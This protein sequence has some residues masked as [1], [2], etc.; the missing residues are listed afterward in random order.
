MNIIQNGSGH[1]Y[2]SGYIYIA[3]WVNGECRTPSTM[4]EMYLR[5]TDGT[6]ETKMYVGYEGSIEYY[7]DK[8]IEG[9]DISKEYYIEARLT[10]PKNQESKENQK[11]IAKITKQGNIGICTNGNKVTVSGNNIKIEK[12]T[13]NRVLLQSI[14]KSQ[15]TDMMQETETNKQ[16]EINLEEGNEKEEVNEKIEE[17]NQQ[18]TNE[19]ETETNTENINTIVQNN[20]DS[21]LEEKNEINAIN[22]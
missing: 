9:L 12:A 1:N 11:Q 17:S 15:N 8:D 18:D 5:S 6:F 14:E 2:I 22:N 21:M 10:N 4:P 13:A 20:F 19:K 3:E 7:F 16:E